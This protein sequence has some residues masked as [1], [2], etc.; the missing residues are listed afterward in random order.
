MAVCKQISKKLIKF[1][2]KPIVALWVL[3]AFVP[4]NARQIQS[5]R[6]TDFL[7]ARY[8][9]QNSRTVTIYAR[10][11]RAMEAA[12]FQPKTFLV[13]GEQSGLHTGAFS[14]DAATQAVF[15]VPAKPFQPGE[16]VTVILTKA[17]KDQNGAPLLSNFLW[18]FYVQSAAGQA[19]FIAAATYNTADGP[20]FI[21]VGDWNGDTR[22][23]LAVPHSLSNNIYTWLNS[24]AGV[25]TQ[26]NMVEVGLVPR[27]LTA[28]DFDADGDMDLAIA[29]EASNSVTV[30]N[31]SGGNFS[32]RS[33]IT[34]GAE[35]S[36]ISSGDLNGDGF[37]DL[38]IPENAA[39]AMAVLINS[40]NGSFSPQAPYILAQRPQDSFL[41]DFNSDGF[42]D[43]V[44]THSEA[45]AVSFLAN[46]KNGAFQVSQNFA[47]E[48][49][50]DFV[51]GQDFNRDGQ[52]DL[53]VANRTS[54]TVSIIFNRGGI[55]SAPQN[56]PVGKDPLAIATGDWD[57]DLDVDF[58]VANRQSN[59][60]YLF[61]NNG[62]GQF[63]M[64]TI[65]TTGAGPRFVNSGD[66][67]GDGDLDLAVAN[68]ESDNFRIYLNQNKPAQNRPPGIPVG[69]SPRPRAFVNPN[70]SELRLIWEAPVD[71]DNDSLHFRVEIDRSADFVSPDFS[72]ESKNSRTGF[73]P[74]PPVSQNVD[75]V[76]FKLA[77]PL[78]NGV[79]WWRITAWDGLQYGLPSLPK[80]FIIDAT[81]PQIVRSVLPGPTF[82]PNWYNPNTRRTIDFGV[83]Y[84]ES[85]AQRA[86]F[87]LGALGGIKVVTNIASGSDRMV[88]MPI[89]LTAADGSYSLAATLFDS[90]GNMSKNS[91]SIALDATTPTGTRAS[92]PD[93]SSNETFAVTWKGTATDGAGCGISGKY[94]VRVQIDGGNWNNWLINFAGDST[95]QGAHGHTYGFEAAARDNVGNLEVFSGMAETTTRVDTTSNVDMTRPSISHT[96]TA[97]VDE[98]QSITI[99]AQIQDDRQVV[100]AV[101]F[102]KQSGKRNYQILPMTN[103]GNA[104]RATLTA[105]LIST[106][107][108]D[109]YLRASDGSNFSYHPAANWDTKPNHIS[110]R[111]IGAGNQGMSKDEAQP[112]GSAQSAF[113]MISLPLLL[114]NSQPQAVLEDDLGRYDRTQWRLFLYNSLSGGYAEFPSINPF[115]PGKAFWLIVREPNKRIDSGIGTTVAANQ[116][117]Q[118]AL[119][120]GWNDIGN[121]FVFPVNWRDVKVVQGD[122]TQIMGPYTYR[123]QW[124][125]PNQVTTLSPWEGYAVY[126]AMPAATIA[127]SPLEAAPG[128]ALLKNDAQVDWRLRLEAVCDEAVDGENFIGVSQQAS[129]EWDRF[130]Y[131]EPPPIGEYVSLRFLHEN[132]QTYRGAFSTDFRPPFAGGQIWQFEAATNISPAP[133]TLN[134]QNIDSIPAAF[135]AVLLDLTTFQRLDLRQ[136]REYIFV[137]D[138]N[139]LTRKFELIVGTKAYIKNFD[140]L[141]QPQSF[142]FSANFPNPFNAGTTWFYQLPEA[143]EVSITVLDVLGRKICHL[144]SQKQEA[145]HYRAHWQGEADDGRE[146]GSGIY[147]IKMEAGSFRQ[148]RKVLLIR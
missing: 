90:A 48:T 70:F 67:D 88:M 96:T 26:N 41:G 49:E 104:Y 6:I 7:P 140:Q 115:A 35:P 112:G 124:L 8:S 42:L 102:Y 4:V 138:Q 117:F 39:S 13:Y 136:T 64:D 109:Y 128:Q 51:S 133:I 28:G 145:G 110:V 89:N 146:V 10:F 54:N 12:S 123:G 20:H 92:S 27:V 66:F 63:Q 52:L 116:P 108:L 9:L 141:N 111:I 142:S 137:P 40:G 44:V 86:E 134:F 15:F 74:A 105:A 126:S 135:Q 106:R 61:N 58:A 129:A 100:E 2:L 113:R 36:H 1:G 5:P 73:F 85:Y 25:F 62:A 45:N 125:L 121:P 75:T 72:F 87:D 33:A 23:D 16:L 119:Q 79:Y 43:I 59:D 19:K 101:L 53:V 84:N 94:D 114:E 57:G 81:P 71:Q 60:L 98:G 17:L 30:L 11:D 65:Y 77:T 120:P 32:P 3:S 38:V 143:S 91:T 139:R 97:V 147:I 46:D 103:A 148:T 132:W 95:Y 93:T 18:S 50:P 24:G 144:I 78:Q 56:Y 122:S 55:F 37:W 68:W 69:F 47:A 82:P 127:I 131:L 76:S 130:D 21:G 99:Q 118:I 107:G 22:P 31:N 29:N 80:S 83:Q 34:L 14:Y